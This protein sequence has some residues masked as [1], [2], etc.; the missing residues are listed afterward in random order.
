[1][2]HL[3]LFLYCCVSSIPEVR[4][5]DL[6]A[7][8]Y[9]KSVEG[10]VNDVLNITV[11]VNKIDG[12]FIVDEIFWEPTISYIEPVNKEDSSA[13]TGISANI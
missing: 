5:E 2:L 1:M 11:F 3:L 9:P 13:Y 6:L 7:S 12:E 4:S 8:M 10:L